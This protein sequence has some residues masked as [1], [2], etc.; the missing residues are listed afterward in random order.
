MLTPQSNPIRARFKSSMRLCFVIIL[1]A[2]RSTLSIFN[3]VDMTLC[4]TTSASKLQNDLD[5]VA[6]R[7]TTRSQA[8]KTRFKESKQGQW[9]STGRRGTH[10]FILKLGERSRAMDW[11]WET[12]RELGN[13]LPTRFDI[14]VP[15]LSTSV[16]IQVPPDDT[17]I[18]G[19]K[20]RK[21]LN[22]DRLIK[23]C[24]EMISQTVDVQDL[25]D[26]KSTSGDELD[27]ELAWKGSDGFLEWV[28]WSSTVQGRSRDWAVLA[29][30]AKL[31]VSQPS[32]A[33]CCSC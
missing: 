15:S 27:L 29:G 13:E 8:L 33:C 22:P 18:G 11:Y 1:A 5:R 4:L 7:Q 14:E 17:D 23:T 31:A 24:W 9:L 26:Q 6:G 10:V 25:M 20:V 12:W 28:A 19:R 16:R 2:S 21:E 3:E 32:I 30:I